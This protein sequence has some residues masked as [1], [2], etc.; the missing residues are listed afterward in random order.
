[1]VVSKSEFEVPHS[2]FQTRRREA[3]FVFSFLLSPSTFLPF[4]PP[5][6]AS[7]NSPNLQSAHILNPPPPPTTTPSPPSTPPQPPPTPKSLAQPSP[8]PRSPATQ[9]HP[10][11][12]HRKQLQA[13]AIHR[14][15]RSDRYYRTTSRFPSSSLF[16]QQRKI[17]E[18]SNDQQPLRRSEL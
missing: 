10:R 1:M 12:P 7:T 8:C 17:V 16:H 11:F 18:G 14:T 3:D 4:H 2:S 15:R 5:F 6:H 13:S 9:T